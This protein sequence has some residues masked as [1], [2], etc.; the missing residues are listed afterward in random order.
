MRGVLLVNMGGPESPEE[1]KVFLSRMFRDPAILPFGKTVRYLLAFIISRSRY[2]K[3]WKKYELIGGTPLVHSTVKT[4]TALQSILGESFVVKHAFSYSS[5]DIA[6]TLNV[7]KKE[8]ISKIHVIPL[9][10][11]SS[12]TT[13]SSVKADIMKVTDK[14]PF[15]DLTVQ[16]EFYTHPDFTAFWAF[17]IQKHIKEHGIENPTLVFSAHSIPENL[18][19]KGDT[20]PTGIINSAAFIAENLGFHYEAAFQSGM[21]RGKWIGPDVREHLR[22]MKEEGIDDLVVIPISFVHEN[23]ETKYDLDHELIPYAKEVLGFKH[24]SRVKLPEADLLF[25]NMLVDLVLKS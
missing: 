19:L 8:G 18:V 13:T 22:T 6:D 25:V 17:Q 24:V 5:P 7:F 21:K 2:R 16:E 20:Y 11:Q 1:L 15:F 10:P 4:A 23:L 9:Y 12:F 3:S 14:D